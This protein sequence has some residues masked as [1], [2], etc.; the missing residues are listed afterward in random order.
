MEGLPSAPWF[1]RLGYLSFEWEAVKV[2]KK[3]CLAVWFI[4]NLVSAPHYVSHAE[5][6][7]MVSCQNCVAWLIVNMVN[8]HSW[9]EC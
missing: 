4:V 5:Y 8:G 6:T 3:K 1:F 9:S 7:D 2:G